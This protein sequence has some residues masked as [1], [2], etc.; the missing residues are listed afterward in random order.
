MRSDASLAD[1]LAAM[2]ARRAER[3]P[4]VDASGSAIGA[5]ALS[6]LVR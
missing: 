5:I 4:V 1:A 2:I 6:D 3:L